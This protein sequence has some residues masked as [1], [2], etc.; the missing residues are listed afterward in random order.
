MEAIVEV[1]SK[2]VVGAVGLP[3]GRR[4]GSLSALRGLFHDSDASNAGLLG[5]RS[6]RRSPPWVL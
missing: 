5:P 4:V 3:R 1:S 2:T 6:H